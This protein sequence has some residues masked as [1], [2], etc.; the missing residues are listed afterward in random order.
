MKNRRI[1]FAALVSC[2]WL[3][4][5]LPAACQVVVEEGVTTD[6]VDLFAK[7]TTPEKSGFLAM[8]ASLLLPGLGQQ[9]LGQNG[10]ALTY[11]SAE[12]LFIFGVVFC[13][14]YSHQISNN[15]KSFAWEHANVTG[16]AGADDNFWQ[17]LRYYGESDGLNQSVSLGY[18]E[19]QELIYRDQ[20]HDYLTPNLQW[21]WDDPSNMKT[22]GKLLDKSKAYQ[23]AASFFIGAMVL[24][25]LVSFVDARFS[26]RH[27]TT[28]PRS[29]LHITPSCD[30]QSGS[31]GVRLSAEF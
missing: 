11:F 30:P 27:Q 7:R 19:Q 31:S 18:N 26:A 12:A 6:T 2:A 10:R 23:V 14:G 5:V 28:A 13:N 9:Y 29:A 20:S 22:Y 17:N 3:F 25:R 21:R 15:A 16:G 4:S 8:T 24:D 1:S